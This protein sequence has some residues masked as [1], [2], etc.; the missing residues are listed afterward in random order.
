M[1]YKINNF[2]YHELPNKQIVVQSQNGIVEVFEDGMKNFIKIIDKEMPSKEI[3]AA[4]LQNYFGRNTTEAIEFLISYGI[5]S[6]IEDLNFAINRIIFATNDI[7]LY[8]LVNFLHSNQD[9]DNLFTA[10]LNENDL[11]DFSFDSQDL[12]VCFFNPYDRNLIK[13]TKG[14]A[15]KYNMLIQIGYVY[16]NDV[17]IDNFYRESWK[18][19]CHFCNINNIRNQLRTEVFEEVTYQHILD[20][21][22]EKDSTFKVE[23]AFNQSQIVFL[24]NTLLMNVNKFINIPRNTNYTGDLLNIIKLNMEDYSVVVDTAVHWEL[25][26]CYD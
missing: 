9:A 14:V 12:L 10:V 4:N 16:N 17:F 6:Q 25:C 5:L 22:F 15:D 18:N 8:N 24:C 21:I 3:T 13:K 1:T 2:I 23:T 26:D 11:N 20:D 7:K 19:P